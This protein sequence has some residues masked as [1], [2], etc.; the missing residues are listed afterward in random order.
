[1]TIIID[2]SGCHREAE[3]RPYVR[4]ADLPRMPG[5]RDIEVFLHAEEDVEVLRPWLARLARICIAFPRFADLD[6]YASARALRRMGFSGQLR[7]T[8]NV[9]ASHYTIARRAGFDDIAL[10]AAQALRQR[11]EHW[12]YMGNWHPADAGSRSRR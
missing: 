6:G 11:P 10:T 4:P 2:D 1:M 12:R 5:A 9:L 3:Q 7:A 8:G